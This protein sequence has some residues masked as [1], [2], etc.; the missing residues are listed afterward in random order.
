MLTQNLDFKKNEFLANFEM[1]FLRQNLA[2]E[3]V[4]KL[5]S[6][7]PFQSLDGII[8]F[9]NLIWLCVTI[10]TFCSWSSVIRLGDFWKFLVTNS[11]SK[12]AQMFGHFW[13]IFKTS[14][15]KL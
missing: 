13:G 15:L 3:E 5:D 8:Y 1:T 10:N 12:V 14:L 4:F 11:L 9:V 7:N 2:K 6:L